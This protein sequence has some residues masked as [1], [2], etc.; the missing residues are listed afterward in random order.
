M[1]S[2]PI[3]SPKIETRTARRRVRAASHA[4]GAPSSTAIALTMNADAERVVEIERVGRLDQLGVVA[5]R[6]ARAGPDAARD[7]RAEALDRH[8]GD[9]RDEQTCEKHEPGREQRPVE[10]GQA[11]F[12]IARRCVRYGQE[13]RISGA[14]SCSQRFAQASTWLA[15]YSK[16]AM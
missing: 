13:R 11:R 5:Q 4:S 1:N 12:C 3:S 7:E 8:Q 10:R 15:M 2:S 16:S 14:I 6:P 9:R